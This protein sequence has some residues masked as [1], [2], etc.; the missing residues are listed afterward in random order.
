MNIRSLYLEEEAV[1][2]RAEGL[3]MSQQCFSLD[4]Y[5]ELYEEYRKLL[6]QMKTL[7]NVADL[8]QAEL[9]TL[10]EEL[11]KVSRI[12]GLTELYNRRYFREIFL[13]TWQQAV[14]EKDILSLLMID[15]DYFKKYNDTYGHLQG[16]ECLKAV[17]AEFQRAVG[18]PEDFV[19]R[20]GGEEFVILLPHSDAEAAIDVAKRL[21]QNIENLCMEHSASPFGQ[22]VTISVGI[23]CRCPTS[24]V[25]PNTLLDEADQALY[26]AK[27]AGRNCF[28]LYV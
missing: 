5:R 9:K 19:A 22:R 16:D 6:K 23:A 3:L 15:I 26:K 24:D 10:S 20:F 8:T 18:H 14:E 27:A 4:V 11:G 12:D 2:K 1:L 28:K 17:A 21:L 25:K 7:V 13:H